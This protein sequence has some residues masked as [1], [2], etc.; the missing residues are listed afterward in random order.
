MI[1][2]RFIPVLSRNLGLVYRPYGQAKLIHTEGSGDAESIV[3]ETFLID[4]GADIT[5]IPRRAGIELRLASVEKD[6][7]QRLGG[8]SGSI[9][10]AYR[11]VEMEIG[12]HRFSCTIAWAQTDSVPF[13]LGR[14]DVFDEFNVELRQK[15]R[16]TFFERA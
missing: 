13:I 2:F 16:V 9:L 7:L 6:E 14:F 3:E 5:V 4:S 1:A 10:M 8:I 11:Q 12:G 15:E